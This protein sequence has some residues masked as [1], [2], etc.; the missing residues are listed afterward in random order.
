MKLDIIIPCYNTTTTLRRAVESSL[1]QPELNT[2]WLIDDAS[3]DDTWQ[4]IQSLAKQYPN[5][6]QAQRLPENGGVARARNWGAL[7][8]QADLLAFLDADDAYQDNALSAAY[9]SF[10]HF[11]YLGLIRLRLQP[12]GL[13]EKYATHPKLAHGWRVLEMTVGGNTVFRRNFL[14]ACGGFPQDALFRTFGGEDGALGIAT[15]HNSVVGTLFDA[16]EPA[17]LHYCREGMHAE[18]LL[19]AELFGIHDRNVQPENMREA[20]AVTERIG[21]QLGS[22]KTILNMPEHGTMPLIVSRSEA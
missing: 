22:L 3:T 13:P 15:V 2:L 10:Q 14:L 4:L 9:F 11:A 5:K 18:R 17:V 19:D 20:N 21:Q 16:H 7:Q 12:V 6:I 8:S 1:K